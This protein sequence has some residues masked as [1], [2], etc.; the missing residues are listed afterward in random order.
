[1]HRIP[2][3]TFPFCGDNVI[4]TFRFDCHG[5]FLFF[6]HPHA[7]DVLP[8]PGSEDVAAVAVRP[9]LGPVAGRPEA[10]GE[11]GLELPIGLDELEEEEPAPAALEGKIPVG[12]EVILAACRA[13][14]S[15]ARRRVPDVDPGPAVSPRRDQ[16]DA[17]RRCLAGRRRVVIQ[18]PGGALN[19]PDRAGETRIG[20]R[21]EY[22]AEA[23]VLVDS[24]RFVSAAPVVEEEVDG[25][26]ETWIEAM[27]EAGPAL[28]QPLRRDR[29]QVN[30]QV[31]G[32]SPHV[33]TRPGEVREGVEGVHVLPPA[34]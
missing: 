33:E 29:L 23:L 25:A 14:L 5:A 8:G 3:E 16:V 20:P 13:R 10:V 21:G 4:G 34:Q 26:R 22:P 17:D 7:Q 32:G 6:Y 18:H 2:A 19:E 24:L 31:G 9:D 1:V 11:V 12:A 28:G 30:S 15:L 27:L